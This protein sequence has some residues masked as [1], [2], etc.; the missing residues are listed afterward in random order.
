MTTKTEFLD[1]LTNFARQRSGIEF[2]N[3][4]DWQ[5]FNSERRSITA[6]LARFNVLVRSVIHS[7]ITYE[8]LIAATRAFS[9]RLSWDGESF[10]YC[11]GQYFPTEYRKAAC[12]V[13]AAALWEYVRN[14]CMPKSSGTVER[15]G[16]TFEAYDGI[17]GGDWLRRYFRREF[18]R[19][20]A[21][22]YFD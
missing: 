2:G 6:D 9:G 1:K 16:M 4:G 21:A 5:S 12:A 13:L 10:S 18:G 11:A 14:Y 17:S 22:R 3:Y 20:I 8:D 7:G 19:G 15:N